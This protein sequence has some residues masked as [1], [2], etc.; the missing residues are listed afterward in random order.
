MRPYKMCDELAHVL[1][2]RS[3]D[4][5]DIKRSA[6][7]LEAIFFYFLEKGQVWRLCRK[8]TLLLSSM[9][10]AGSLS[11]GKSEAPRLKIWSR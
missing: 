8:L 5:L 6:H 2:A 1:W 9:K 3:L 10:A 4:G 11:H 7:E